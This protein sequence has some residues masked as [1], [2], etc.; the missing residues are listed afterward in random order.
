MTQQINLYQPIFRTPKRVFSALA[1]LQVI[2][3]ISIGCASVYGYSAW[4]VRELA[5]RVGTLERARDKAV[6]QLETLRQQFPARTASP[7]LQA[8][9]ASLRFELQQAEVLASTLANGALGN[10]GGLSD[11]LAGLARQHVAGTWLTHID[12]ANGG[13]TIGVHG[14]AL[15]PDLVPAYVRRLANEPAFAG[16]SFSH[17]QLE[18]E[19]DEENPGA[20]V[21]FSIETEGV[22][23]EDDKNG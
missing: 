6:N 17:F 14:R 2:G 15:T 7:L 13:S 8:E 22:V 18:Q 3:L 23:S 11:Y 21:E 1:L 9:L 12:I 10:T 19:T 4:Q 16:K 5:Q 20:A